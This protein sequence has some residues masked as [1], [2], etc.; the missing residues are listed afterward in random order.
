MLIALSSIIASL[1]PSVVANSKLDK[2]VPYVWFGE[3]LDAETTAYGS[4]S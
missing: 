3:R 4:G 1:V 2:E